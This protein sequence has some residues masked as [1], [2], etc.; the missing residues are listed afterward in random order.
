MCE[1]SGCK[2][3]RFVTIAITITRG[4]LRVLFCSAFERSRVGQHADE[5][6]RVQIAREIEAHNLCRGCG[7][8]GESCKRES[9]IVKHERI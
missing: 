8:I 2:R 4:V 6:L 3:A 5:R 7:R 1:E 9:A